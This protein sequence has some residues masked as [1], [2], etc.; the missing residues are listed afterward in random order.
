MVVERRTRRKYF[1]SYLFMIRV[2]IIVSG[3]I[4]GVF[5]RNNTQK[6]AQELGLVGWVRN[7]LSWKVEVL[8]EGRKEQIEQL[9]K[10]L[11]SGPRLAKVKDV[12]IEYGDATGEFNKFDIKEY[13]IRALK[14]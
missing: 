12:K 10:W 2:Q 9:I 4:Q 3:R 11:N 13:G 14:I 5:F 6:K 8:C 1:S 7:L